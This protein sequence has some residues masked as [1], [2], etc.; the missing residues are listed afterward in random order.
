M[1]RTQRADLFQL[2]FGISNDRGF[3]ALGLIFSL[4]QTKKTKQNI[5]RVEWSILSI[6]LPWG[7]KI[8][9]SQ[10]NDGQAFE[11]TA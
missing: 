1:A 5:F 3:R 10:I 9:T 4:W 6:E 2:L 7:H 11:N 8:Y